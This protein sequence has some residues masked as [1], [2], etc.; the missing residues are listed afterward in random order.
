V[1]P[2]LGYYLGLPAWAYPGWQGPYFPPDRP[3]LASYSQ[4][5]NTVEGNTTF[6]GIP[7]AKTVDAWR[8]IVEGS[9]FRF[10]F[11]LPRSVTHD[12]RPSLPDLKL[13]FARLEPL[14]EHLGPFMIQLPGKVGT[15]QLPDL[16]RLIER[17]PG[18]HRYV[19]EVRDRQLFDEPERLEPLIEEF[20]LG[21]VMLDS[22][23]IYEGDR[24]HPE[25]LDALHEKPDVPVLDTVYNGIA[26]VRLIL[27]P[28][29]G[30]NGAYIDEWVE[31]SATYLDA[32]Q[33]LYM[34][35]HCPNNQHCPGLAETFHAG[36][37]HRRTGSNMPPLPPYPVPQ[38]ASLL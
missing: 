1:T 35:I 11:K 38:Q 33:Q 7:D 37:R 14:D 15:E 12:R 23:P 20:R 21:R 22:R 28:D 5:F 32:G 8:R 31:R 36:L 34:M 9:S 25:V 16:E 29:I 4:V 17:L 18:R 13:F 19:I 27:H 26:F 24:A 3:A 6:Y 2:E 10:C 30:S